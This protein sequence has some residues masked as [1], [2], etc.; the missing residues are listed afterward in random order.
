LGSP[1][2][3]EAAGSVSKRKRGSSHSGQQAFLL[4]LLVVPRM[5]NRLFV[6]QIGCRLSNSAA[7]TTEKV[8][9]NG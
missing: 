8:A 4:E 3:K 6:S 5:V 7:E 2:F 9:A 1:N